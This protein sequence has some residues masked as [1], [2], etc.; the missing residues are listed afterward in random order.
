MA[1]HLSNGAHQDHL[2][3]GAH[4]DHLSHTVYRD[5]AAV[6]LQPAPEANAVFDGV[7]ASLLQKRGPSSRMFLTVLSKHGRREVQMELVI[8]SECCSVPSGADA[9]GSSSPFVLC[10]HC[11]PCGACISRRSL[12]DAFALTASEAE[13]AIQVF[14]GL[15]M[16]EAAGRLGVSLNTVR[17]HLKSIFQKCDVRSQTQLVRLV[18]FGHLLPSSRPASC[19]CDSR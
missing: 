13:V 19:R 6:R 1:T 18:A 12:Q 7:I 9:V 14:N 15:S 8:C 5:P 3:N 16:P 17:T 11:M 10:V 4:R 2:S